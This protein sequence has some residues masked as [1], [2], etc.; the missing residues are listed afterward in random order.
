MMTILVVACY[1]HD[2][3]SR[4]PGTVVYGTLIEAFK[5]LEYPHVSPVSVRSRNKANRDG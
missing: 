5:P 1:L 4:C 3:D 2:L